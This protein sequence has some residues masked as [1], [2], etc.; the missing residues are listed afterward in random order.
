M[1]LFVTFQPAGGMPGH[2]YLAGPFH[3][4]IQWGT[5]GGCPNSCDTVTKCC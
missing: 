5:Q 4:V 3:A 2:C 1:L